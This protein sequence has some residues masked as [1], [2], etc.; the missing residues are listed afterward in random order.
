MDRITGNHK[1]IGPART[2]ADIEQLDDL[3]IVRAVLAGNDALFEVLIRRYNQRLYRL[4][5]GILGDDHEARDVL[6]EAYVRAYLKLHSFRGPDGFGAWL[7]VITRNQALAVLRTLQREVPTEGKAMENTSQD[8]AIGAAANPQKLLENRRLGAALETAID[9]LPDRFRAVFV[10]RAVEGMSVRETAALLEL[11]EQ[12]VK[13]RFFR[14]RRMLRSRLKHLGNEDAL[15]V[16]E[17]AGAR[18]DALTAATMRRILHNPVER[19]PS[20]AADRRSP[21]PGR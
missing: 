11:K 1:D 8:D 9:R 6:Q 4:A 15:P 17:F 12:T 21:E 13:T 3:Q 14:A 7:H 5:R 16:Y 19:T 2:S 18:C 20:Q 10:L